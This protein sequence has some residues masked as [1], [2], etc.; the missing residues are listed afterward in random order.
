M[1]GE[2][3]PCL[4]SPFRYFQEYLKI[5]K[6]GMPPMIRFRLPPAMRLPAAAPAGA[7][8]RLPPGAVFPRTGPSRPAILPEA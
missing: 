1:V 6:H 4:P 7:A 3:H 2:P 8:H 5:R